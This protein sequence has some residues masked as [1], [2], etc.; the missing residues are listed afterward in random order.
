M[1]LDRIVAV[2][3][4]GGNKRFSI[5]E[6]YHQIEDLITYGEW[7]FRIGY[8]SL[9]RIK[10]KGGISGEA[11]PMVEYILHTLK[12]IDSIDQ[13]LVVGPEKEMREE[14]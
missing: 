3:L 13:V 8:K 11:R 4:A 1:A 5:R 7:Y 2:V 10:R 9:K 6:F 12:R 14:N